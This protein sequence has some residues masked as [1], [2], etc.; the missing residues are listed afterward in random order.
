MGSEESEKV[1]L[2]S[3][4]IIFVELQPIW[5]RYLNVTDRQTDNLP[6]EYVPRSATLRAVKT[7]EDGGVKSIPIPSHLKSVA[8]SY[9]KNKDTVLSSIIY[10]TLWASPFVCFIATSYVNYSSSSLTF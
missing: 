6:W 3:R 7:A 4:E 10:P 2:I 5:P 1:R 8:V 9:L